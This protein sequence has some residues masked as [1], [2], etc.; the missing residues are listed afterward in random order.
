[1]LQVQKPP[2]TC[3]ETL[4]AGFLRLCFCRVMKPRPQGTSG[5]CLTASTGRLQDRVIHRRGYRRR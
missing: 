3:V 2:M 1:M 5:L 4:G